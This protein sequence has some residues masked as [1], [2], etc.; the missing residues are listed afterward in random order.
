MANYSI[1]L[2][3]EELLS[4]SAEKFLDKISIKNIHANK[5]HLSLFP[6][7]LQPTEDSILHWLRRRVIPK[8]RAFVGEILRSLGLHSNDVLGIIDVCKGLS[9]ND[10]FWVTP[11][12][13]TGSF[14]DYNL[15]ENPFSE[16]LS[17]VAYTGYGSSDRAF[18]TSPELT[19][20]GML[21]KA[22]RNING[23]IYLY[24]GGSTG[25]ANA[26]NEPYAEF[27]A[28][29]LANAMGINAVSYDL[30][31]WKGILASTCKLFTDINT[32]YVPMGRMGQL[33]HKVTLAD[34]IEFCASKSDDFTA[35]LKSMLMFD[36][37]IRNEDRHFGNF[38]ARSLLLHRSSITAL[39]YSHRPLPRNFSPLIPCLSLQM[40]SLLSMIIS[41]LEISVTS[42]SAK[43]RFT[44]YTSLSIFTLPSIQCITGL[45]RGC[46][47][48]NSAYGNVQFSS[49]I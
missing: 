9:L 38:V 41:L 17:I 23:G 44:S 30:D 28:A 33:L 4:F 11:S 3:D 12:D 14:S 21:P 26:G 18:T 32:A 6:L 19:T 47:S 5:D 37:L 36:A 22:W 15:Y 29:Q 1:K 35:Q 27:Y 48:L 24:K 8:N 43:N 40:P 16:V 25:A 31:R 20:D 39:A 42:P 10:S 2:Y 7:D 45:M 13:F 46:M 34:T 49:T